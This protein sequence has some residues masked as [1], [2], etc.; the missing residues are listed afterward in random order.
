MKLLLIKL[1]LL[2][3]LP[4]KVAAQSSSPHEPHKFN[5]TPV[6][7]LGGGLIADRLTT[8]LAI[9][10]GDCRESNPRYTRP[11]YYAPI[12]PN[13]RLMWVDAGLVIGGQ[14]LIMKL[15]SKVK[16]LRWAVA[17][18]SYILGAWFGWHGIK[19]MRCA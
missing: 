5:W 11:P 1:L 7:V 3:F 4:I 9:T 17:S 13:Y 10:N 14:A 18:E 16:W 12:Q 8:H 6:L 15:S 19:N 2:I